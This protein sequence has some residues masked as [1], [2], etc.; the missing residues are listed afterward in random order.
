MISI[1][2]S[3]YVHPQKS[4]GRHRLHRPGSRVFRQ[5]PYHNDYSPDRTHASRNRH[6]ERSG[7]DEGLVSP[8]VMT[9]GSY[10]TSVASMEGYSN[11]VSRA[12]AALRFARRSHGPRLRSTTES[13]RW[14]WNPPWSLAPSLFASASCSLSPAEIPAPM[15]S[16]LDLHGR[17]GQPVS[18]QARIRYRYVHGNRATRTA[19]ASMLTRKARAMSATSFG[20]AGEVVG[21]GC[22]RALS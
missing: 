2:P 10:P 19:S 5:N 1:L 6:G 8:M 18:L 4:H 21:F 12:V 3:S 7:N 17:H 13:L 11:V 15:F 14:W 16:M 22:P 20:L 9:V